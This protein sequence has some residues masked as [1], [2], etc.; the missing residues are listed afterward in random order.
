MLYFFFFKQKTAYEMRI[1]DWSSDVCS[2]DL[3]RFTGAGEDRKCARITPEMG[4]EAANPPLF[5]I[6]LTRTPAGP[7]SDSQPL[8]FTKRSPAAP[9]SRPPLQLRGARV[10]QPLFPS[11]NTTIRK[12]TAATSHIQPH[13]NKL[14]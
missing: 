2:S 4:S 8:R 7:F 5:W 12:K 13:A 3:S 1:S 14:T 11:A 9:A 10:R 6:K